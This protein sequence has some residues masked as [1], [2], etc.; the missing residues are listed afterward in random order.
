MSPAAPKAAPAKAK[1]GKAKAAKADQPTDL[2]AAA[3]A[4]LASAAEAKAPAAEASDKAAEKDAKNAKSLRRIT[5]NSRQAWLLPTSE[6]SL[7]VKSFALFASFAV[8]FF[9]R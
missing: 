8:N 2:N 7:P 6:H 4:L 3:D 9:S 5:W 1:T